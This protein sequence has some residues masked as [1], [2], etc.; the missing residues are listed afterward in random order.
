MDKKLQHPP[1][2]EL[3]EKLLRSFSQHYEDWKLAFHNDMSKVEK[4]GDVYDANGKKAYSIVEVMEDMMVRYPEMFDFELTRGPRELSSKQLS[5]SQ[6]HTSNIKGFVSRMP[7]VKD[8]EKPLSQSEYGD[9]VSEL[10][11]DAFDRTFAEYDAPETTLQKMTWYV[12]EHLPEAIEQF[13]IKSSNMKE[14][15][16]EGFDP[17]GT[18]DE[19]GLCTYAGDDEDYELDELEEDLYDGRTE[20]H[21]ELELQPECD[22]HGTEDCDCPA[23]DVDLNEEESY[24]FTFEYN[25]EGKLVPTVD[26]LNEYLRAE[27]NG[28]KANGK[29]EGL[30][31]DPRITELERQP[32]HKKKHKKKR[33]KQV[34]KQMIFD[35]DKTDNCLFCDYEALYGKPP[36]HLMR[37]VDRQIADDDRRGKL[38][39][40]HKDNN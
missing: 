18:K 17:Y 27:A 40:K 6:N 8:N 14:V 11:Q 31:Q 26:S 39:I 12:D 24:D 1:T 9:I 38:K 32:V 37:W 36:V 25:S 34:K 21:I 13:K 20:H 30:A 29:L 15:K 19:E 23:Y 4:S 16:E 10:Y 28:F 2:G 22:I 5:P 35:P 7:P 3:A 33:K